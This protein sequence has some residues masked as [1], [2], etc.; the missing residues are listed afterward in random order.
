MKKISRS[1]NGKN[2]Y[3]D[4][5]RT[6]EPSTEVKILMQSMKVIVAPGSLCPSVY[7]VDHLAI[8]NEKGIYSSLFE[9]ESE[10]GLIY[11]LFPL[12]TFW[13]KL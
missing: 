9:F 8:E 5:N 10:W 6:L 4:H 13:M 1:A 12:K 7:K 3:N 2:V 11:S